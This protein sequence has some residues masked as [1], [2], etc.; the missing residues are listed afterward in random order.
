MADKTAKYRTEIQQKDSGLRPSSNLTRYSF[1]EF[2]V[3]CLLRVLERSLQQLLHHAAF[4]H[5][6]SSSFYASRAVTPEELI[7]ALLFP[8]T[9]PYSTHIASV[10]AEMPSF[11]AYL[12]DI[13]PPDHSRDL[14]DFF[15]LESRST[16]RVRLTETIEKMMFVS[17]E[18]S[19]AAPETL[20]M[21]EGIVQ[22]QVIE[23]LTRS[24]ALAA[25]RGV[26]SISTDDLIFLIR[27]DKA[28]VSRLR[29]FLSWK[30]VR[31]NVKD[32]ED[33]AGDG[34]ADFNADDPL[35]G[36]GA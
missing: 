31:K 34:G 1:V 2:S 12:S 28:K 29:T 35:P 27:H 9:Y 13:T 19:E 30:D 11:R 6:A 26:R 24:T 3:P 22:Q 21:I 33:K 36:G 4:F 20:S 17:G 23:M 5:F 14:P 15:D 8:Q 25:R 16:F 32:S 10:V 7:R 18:T